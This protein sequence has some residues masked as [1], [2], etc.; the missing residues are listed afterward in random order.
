M[1]RVLI[2]YPYM[3]AYRIAF[4]DT[5]RSQLLERGVELVIAHG[6]PQREISERGDAMTLPGSIALD[7]RTHAVRGREITRWKLPDLA[8]IDLLVVEQA[9][10]HPAVYRAV[11]R[12]PHRCRLAMWGHGQ[13]MTK[14]S[15]R[16]EKR[17]KTLLTNRC[18]WFFAYT[19][20]GRRTVTEGGF[21]ADRVTVVQ[22]S[23]ETQPA[24]GPQTEAAAHTG[25]FIGGL[26]EH[27]LLGL[28]LDAAV[29]IRERD[30]EFRLIVAGH[31]SDERLVQA[32]AERHPWIEK[33]PY[34][35]VEEKAELATEASLML[36]PGRVGLV[37][38]DAMA[39]GLPLITTD[40]PYHAPEIE[41]LIENDLLIASAQ[42]A[43]AYASTVA[44]YLGDSPARIDA[45]A[46]MLAA[47]PRYSLDAMADNFTRGILSAL[48]AGRR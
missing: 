28:L 26:D 41:Y 4:F 37:A 23:Q 38:V 31:G 8:D 34:V 7:Q 6:A 25:L 13:T 40:Y 47:A 32:A 46:R 3:P 29:L 39:L 48:K 30:P 21:P 20:G 1:T 42:D 12:R 19:E 5:V 16:L 14:P 33:R 35:G 15:T 43:A 2:V 9:L 10:R 18:D 22:N 24:A 36:M 17:A 11:V 27:K 45:R 44:A